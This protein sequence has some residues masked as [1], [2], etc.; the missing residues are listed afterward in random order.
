MSVSLLVKVSVKWKRM[1]RQSVEHQC[2]VTLDDLCSVYVSELTS[3][4]YG[5]YMKLAKY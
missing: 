2:I 4:G 5:L 1:H 3:I